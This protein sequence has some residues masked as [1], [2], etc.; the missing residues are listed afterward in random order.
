MCVLFRRNRESILMKMCE[1]KTMSVRVLIYANDFVLETV[2]C[3]LFG[4]CVKRCFPYFNYNALYFVYLHFTLCV[5][6][7]DE[8]SCYAV[9]I[10]TSRFIVSVSRW[11]LKCERT[12]T[13][14]NLITFSCRHSKQRYILLFKTTP[15][16]AKVKIIDNRFF[17]L[18]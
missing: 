9:I 16:H 10:E 14:A 18:L 15:P 3:V 5:F 12:L 1:R 11:V 4:V 6:F 13:Y 7:C 8:A 17:R 2:E